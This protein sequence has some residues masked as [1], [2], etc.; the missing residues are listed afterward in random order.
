MGSPVASPVSTV[1]VQ[2]RGPATGHLSFSFTWSTPIKGPSRVLT[3]WGHPWGKATSPLSLPRSLTSASSY[4]FVHCTCLASLPA[5]TMGLPSTSRYS[6]ERRG[7]KCPS[8]LTLLSS[9]AMDNSSHQGSLSAHGWKAHEA[10]SHNQR[11]AKAWEGPPPPQPH[12]CVDADGSD[13]RDLKIVTCKGRRCGF[14]WHSK[15]RSTGGNVAWVHLQHSVYCDSP[16]TPLCSLS[17]PWHCDQRYRR[18]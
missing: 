3:V 10:R 1:S 7:T 16:P 18:G 8:Q 12:L 17:L 9:A 2:R 6:W 4:T 5:S 14:D 13:G 11:E 15:A